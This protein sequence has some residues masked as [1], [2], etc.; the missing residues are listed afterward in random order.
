MKDNQIQKHNQFKTIND[1]SQIISL[2]FIQIDSFNVW[3]FLLNLSNLT[4]PKITWVRNRVDPL[5]ITSHKVTGSS[6]FAPRGKFHFI[7]RQPCKKKKP[8]RR[9][10]FFVAACL[11]F[12]ITFPSFKKKTPNELFCILFHSNKWFHSHNI[13]HFDQEDLIKATTPIQCRTK[14]IQH[15]YD[16]TTIATFSHKAKLN[17]F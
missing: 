9:K 17:D 15:I 5:F 6:H 3:N 2:Q 4:W 1:F 12:V 10:T 13:Y 16:M 8:K 7:L 14:S 11:F